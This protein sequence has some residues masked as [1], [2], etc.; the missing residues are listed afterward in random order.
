M[1]IMTPNSEPIWGRSG[2]LAAELRSALL[3]PEV[4]FPVNRWTARPAKSNRVQACLPGCWSNPLT[5][6]LPMLARGRT[7]KGTAVCGPEGPFG[8]SILEKVMRPYWQFKKSTTLS[9]TPKWVVLVLQGAHPPEKQT[10]NKQCM[11]VFKGTARC[12]PSNAR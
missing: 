12:G 2:A 3:L 7:M 4:R 1:N 10:G 5:L 11:S 8:I 6:L 9:P